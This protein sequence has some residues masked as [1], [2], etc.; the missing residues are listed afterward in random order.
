M[1]MKQK[2]QSPIVSHTI[3]IGMTAVLVMV[4]LSSFTN[5]T[6]KYQKFVAE[7]EIEQ[8][9][10][11]IRSNVERIYGPENYTLQENTT[12]SSIRIEL[13]KKIA[14]KK[15]HSRFFNNSVEV[16]IPELGMNV[17]CKIGF[18]ARFNGSSDGGVTKIYW[19]RYVNGSDEIGMI[20]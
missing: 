18:P 10:F 12:L 17:T 8:V 15:Y 9:C 1:S 14:D 3:A 20:V 19:Q 16:L 2:A 7:Y 13:P 11:S 6:G 5:I 4:I